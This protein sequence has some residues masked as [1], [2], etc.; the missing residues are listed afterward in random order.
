MVIL[1]VALEVKIFFVVLII[2]GIA[3]VAV[4]SEDSEIRIVVQIRVLIMP[5]G[6]L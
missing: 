6:A 4:H 2:I 3:A 5:K 1:I